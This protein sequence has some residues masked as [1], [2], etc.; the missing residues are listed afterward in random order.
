MNELILKNRDLLLKGIFAFKYLE[1]DKDIQKETTELEQLESEIMKLKET[2]KPKDN[3]AEY[4]KKMNEFDQIFQLNQPELLEGMTHEDKLEQYQTYMNLYDDKLNYIL[5]NKHLD[6][7]TKYIDG[8][9]YHYL[10]SK[11]IRI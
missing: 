7:R 3:Y 1:D 4:T 2:R 6:V 11:N 8:K 5:Q 10:I 9:V